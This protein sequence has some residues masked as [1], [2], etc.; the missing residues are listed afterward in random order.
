MRFDKR[1]KY[2]L[3]WNDEKNLHQWSRRNISHWEYEVGQHCKNYKPNKTEL[4][5][6]VFVWF[7]ARG[8]VVWNIF[9]SNKLRQKLFETKDKFKNFRAFAANL[10]A[11]LSNEYHA[12]VQWETSIGEYP[13]HKDTDYERLDIAMQV[14]INWDQFAE[15]VWRHRKLI[16]E[17]WVKNYEG[18]FVDEDRG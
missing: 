12:R 1:D 17:D 18:Y 4:V 10:H 7:N 11:W 14:A 8:L 16:T 2:G 13:L 3:Y 6:N 9:E 15:Y 5:W